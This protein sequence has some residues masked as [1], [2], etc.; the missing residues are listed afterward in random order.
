MPAGLTP[1]ASANLGPGLVKATGS[2]SFRTL[3]KRYADV[4]NPMDFGATGLGVADDTAAIQAAIDSAY[5]VFIPKGTYSVTQLSI[6]TRR[7]IF[8]CGTLV[9]RDDST[10]FVIGVGADDTIIDGIELVGY[11]STDD[12]SQSNSGIY[13]LCVGWSIRN[14]TIRNFSRSGIVLGLVSGTGISYQENPMSITNCK[15][16]H[17]GN[18]ID[19]RS[20]EY[21]SISNNS[22]YWN[23]LNYALSDFSSAIAGGDEECAGIVGELGNIQI[24]SNEITQNAYGVSLISGLTAVNPDHSLISCNT[25][26]HN[27]ACGL[28]IKN[29]KNY[30]MVISNTLLSNI[31][32]P[33]CPGVLPAGGASKDFIIYNGHALVVSGNS[34]GETLVYGEGR[35]RWTNNNLLYSFVET[36]APTAGSPLYDT[37]GITANAWNTF[38]ENWFYL[39]Q[40]PTLFGGYGN[41]VRDNVEGSTLVD[42]VFSAPSLNATWSSPS[43]SFGTYEPIRYWRES[44]NKVRIVGSI[45]RASGAST[46]PFQLPSGFRPLGG[47]I[48]APCIISTTGTIGVV[49]VDTAGNVYVFTPTNTQPILL[50]VTFCI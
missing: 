47:A 37:W 50:D 45:E 33:S 17:N 30:E 8:G 25:I 44:G 11:N 13:L 36:S 21:V 42:N 7:N 40:R 19:T 4:A 14:C 38:S 48:D 39:F 46:N 29:P 16:H 24:V 1:I 10:M 27:I 5:D 15:I 43:T 32:L 9:S 20:Y 12:T 26:N 23:G 22:I 34:I 31:A 49:R 6:P 41:I 3:E 28:L 18:G 35:C 2:T